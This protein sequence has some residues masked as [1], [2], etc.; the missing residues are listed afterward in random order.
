MSHFTV[1]LDLNC[2]SSNVAPEIQLQ[3]IQALELGKVV[4][5]PS[6]AFDLSEYEKPLLTPTI[7]DKRRKNISYDLCADKIGRTNVKPEQVSILQKMMQRYAV[8]SRQLLNNLFP[9]YSTSV[10][11]AR[12]SYRPVE[13]AG[14]RAAS[15]RKDDTLLHVDS[16]P[17]T[18][19]SGERILRMFTNINPHGKSRVWRVGEPFDQVVQKFAPLVK[20]PLIGSAYLNQLFKITRGKRSLYDHYMLNMHNLMKSDPD[21]QLT[22]MQQELQLHPGSTWLVY[23]DQVSHAAIAGQYVLEQ[24]FHLPVQALGNVDSAPLKVLE[25]FLSAA[26]V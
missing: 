17:A 5:L 8:C 7:C 16:F 2:W 3:A 1:N 14:R 9:Q 15:P 6:L 22:V 23:T 18:P 13:I 21:Y 25:K 26:L 12:T 10:R 24:T 19:V 20:K 4:C 11:Q